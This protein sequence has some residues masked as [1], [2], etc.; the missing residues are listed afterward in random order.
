MLAAPWWRDGLFV[1]RLMLLLNA[2]WLSAA[3]GLNGDVFATSA[4]FAVMGEVMTQ[5][6][7][8]WA[9]A[10]AAVVQ[11]GSLVASGRRL[12]VAGCVASG[13]TEGCVAVLFWL[14]N[15]HS[16]GHGTYLLLVLLSYW[17]ILAEGIGSGRA[18]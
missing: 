8:A 11:A 10:A 13:V 15:P 5:G 16:T 1:V 14:G 3:L 17:T 7:W 9:F 6:H 2:A 12:R 18:A 4:S